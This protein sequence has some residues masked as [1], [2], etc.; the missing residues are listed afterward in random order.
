MNICMLYCRIMKTNTISE[1]NYGRV[2]KEKNMKKI[3][4]VMALMMVLTMMFY[5]TACGSGS[6][7]STGETAGQEESVQANDAADSEETQAA[8]DTEDNG[9]VNVSGKDPSDITIAGL[10]HVESYIGTMMQQGMEDAAAKYGVNLLTTNYNSDSAKEAEA[11]NTY[12]AQGVDGIVTGMS[13]T[14]MDAYRQASEQGILISAVNAITVGEEFMVSAITYDQAGLGRGAVDYA[15]DFIKENLDGKANV[16]IIRVMKGTFVDARGDAF[17][18]GLKEAFGEDAQ[19]VSESSTYVVSEALQQATDAIT[20]NPDINIIYCEGEDA[21]MGAYTAIEN[22]G[23]A[24]KVFLFGIDGNQQLAERLLDE[25][26]VILQGTC[27]QDPYAFGYLGAENLILTLM[28][29]R[30]SSKGEITYLTPIELNKGDLDTVQ[31]YYD[32]LVAASER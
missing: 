12:V 30:E 7:T 31:K 21:L 22:T 29:E 14:M 8:G 26:D 19:L 6:S 13:E 16:H 18:E 25:N 9:N 24:G 1:N 4:K 10:I 17:M 23:N 11:I 20:G 32:D 5:V 3:K 28:G 15:V 27:A 2:E